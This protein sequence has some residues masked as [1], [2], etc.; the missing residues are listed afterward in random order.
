[1]NQLTCIQFDNKSLNCTSNILDDTKTTCQAVSKSL[2]IKQNSPASG[3]WFNWEGASGTCVFP[4]YY[5]G[6]KYDH[7]AH[8]GENGNGF[9]FCSFTADEWLG[10]TDG[11][12]CTE[13]C[14]I[15][16]Q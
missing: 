8:P 15:R 3:I 11:G 4:F 9:G 10:P 5:K 14:P 12:W 2:F 7:C 13:E 16:K 1:M 6:I